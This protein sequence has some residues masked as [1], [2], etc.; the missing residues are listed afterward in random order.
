MRGGGII[1]TMKIKMFRFFLIC[2]VIAGLSSC[3]YIQKIQGRKIADLET[4]VSSLEDEYVPIK[5]K[6]NK[7]KGDEI[8][9]KVLFQDLEGNT[10]KEETVSILG[11]EIHFDFQV[12]QLTPEK[13]NSKKV[14]KSTLAQYMFYP[15]KIYSEKVDRKMEL[16]CARSMTKKVSPPF[17]RD[18]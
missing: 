14:E 1:F 11:S 18:L 10:I 7:T 3:S 13:K 9:I 5:F 2:M 16:T 12:I 15:Y 8:S 17:T 4:M 6:L